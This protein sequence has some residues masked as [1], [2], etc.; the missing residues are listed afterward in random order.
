MAVEHDVKKLVRLLDWIKRTLEAA[1][2]RIP[3]DDR[4]SGDPW[5]EIVLELDSAT[6]AI[7]AITNEHSSRWRELVAHGLTGLQLAFKEKVVEKLI[8][9][10][11]WDDILDFINKLL[12]SLGLS[13]VSEYK[14]ALWKLAKEPLIVAIPPL[15]ELET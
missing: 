9:W 12:E 8:G 14:D 4:V 11:V 15:G 13:L 10:K 7:R 2:Q 3:Q 6:A 5:P 1:R